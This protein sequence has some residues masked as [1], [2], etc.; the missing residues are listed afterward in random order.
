MDERGAY[1][2][3]EDDL[4]ERWVDERVGNGVQASEVYLAEQ[5][6]FLTC[7]DDVAAAEAHPAIPRR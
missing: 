4:P 7:L 5:L 2:L 6:A 3:I 1:H